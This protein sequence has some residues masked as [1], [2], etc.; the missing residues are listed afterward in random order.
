M[1][2]VVTYTGLSC[3]PS[4]S[5]WSAG[6]RVVGEWN[7]LSSFASPVKFGFLYQRACEAQAI[8]AP[9][10]PFNFWGLVFN[11]IFL[12]S[13][14][15]SSFWITS[16][17]L[18]GNLDT[19]ESVHLGQFGYIWGEGDFSLSAHCTSCWE[20]IGN[21][22]SLFSAYSELWEEICV[23]DRKEKERFFL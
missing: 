7:F 6:V 9:A 21:F 16:H 8:T 12:F 15:I 11:Y 22:E 3:F 5:F 17:L 18:L 13:V 2:E 19:L 23:E 20:L 10:S 4:S 1:V 14:C